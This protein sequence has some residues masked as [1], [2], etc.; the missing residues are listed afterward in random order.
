MDISEPDMV[1]HP[2]HY[3]SKSGLEVIDVIDAFTEDLTGMDA[4]C[5]G[6]AIKY[7]LRWK[8]KN[9]VEDIKKAIWYLNKLVSKLEKETMK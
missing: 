4:V 9:G 7:I 6:N 5:T 8:Q 1:N 3:Q 2:P